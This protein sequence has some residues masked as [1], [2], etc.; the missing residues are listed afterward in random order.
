MAG[1]STKGSIVLWTFSKPL[2]GHGHESSAC[3]DGVAV[4]IDRIWTVKI[5][6]AEVGL[7]PLEMTFPG[8]ANNSFTFTT[9]CCIGSRPIFAQLTPLTN[10]T[11]FAFGDYEETPWITTRN[12]TSPALT[13]GTMQMQ[14]TS[15]DSTGPSANVVVTDEKHPHFSITVMLQ[16]LH[17]AKRQYP[18]CVE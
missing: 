8:S 9:F 5:S 15:S 1:K 4:G 3:V 18:C 17:Y 7:V 16:A 11:I 2:K 12:P 14:T 13:S 6:I 10:G